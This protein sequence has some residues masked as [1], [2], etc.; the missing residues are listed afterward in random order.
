MV[1]INES[2]VSSSVLTVFSSNEPLKTFSSVNFFNAIHILNDIS[3]NSCKISLIVSFVVTLGHTMVFKIV[4]YIIRSILIQTKIFRGILMRS[5]SRSR[6][7]LSQF[8]K[9]EVFTRRFQNF[10]PGGIFNFTGW[11][12]FYRMVN[13]NN[14]RFKTNRGMTGYSYRSVQPVGRTKTWIFP[15]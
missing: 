9:P 13:Q 10:S 5:F 11:F 4:R 12:I 3:L 6:M 14:Y 7:F 1:G 15:C 8:F 2:T